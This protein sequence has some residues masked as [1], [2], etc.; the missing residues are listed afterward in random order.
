MKVHAADPPHL[1]RFPLPMTATPFNTGWTYRHPLGPFAAAQGDSATPTPVTLPHDALRD[2][3]RS[4]DV[5]GKGAGAYYPPGAY[6]YLKTFDAPADW[7][8]RAVRLEFQGAFRHAMVFVNDE[9][10]GNRADGYAR[11]FVDIKPYLNLGDANEVR[12]EVRSGQDSRW[13]SGCGLHRPVVL[14]VDEPV[15]IVPDGVRVTTLDV[16]PDQAVVEVATR[17]A[18][19]TLLSTTATLTTTIADPSGRPVES[20]ETPVTLAPGETAL[21]RHRLY[22]P[23]PQRWSV[24]TPQLYAAASTLVASSLSGADSRSEVRTTF[25]VRTI[26]LDPRRGLRINGEPV[27]LRGACLH[28]DNGPL[29]AAAVGRAEERRIELLRAAGF[30]AIRATHNPLSVA[31]LEACDRLGMLVMDEAFDMWTRGKSTHDYAL[32]FPQ[33]WAADLESMVAKDYNHACVIM[34]SLG[35]EIVETGTPHGAR[36]ARR[37]AEHLRVLDPTRLVTNGVNAA[38]AVLDE[39]PAMMAEAGV[40]LNE[41]MANVGDSMN[42]LGSG[43]SVT[44]RTAESSSVL[45]VLGLNYAD[46]RYALDQELFPHRVIVGSE[47]FPSRIGT[48]WPMVREH[49]HVIGDFTWTGWDYLGEVGIGATA[50]AE[51][52]GAVAALERE[53]PYLTAWCGDLD[54]TGWRRPVSFYRE[55]VYGLRTEPYIAVRRPEHSERTVALQSPWAWSDSVSSWTWPGHEGRPVV[56]EVYADAD[57]VA[58]V[59]DG[60]EVARSPVGEQHPLMAVLETSYVPGEL[61]AVAFRGGAETGRTSLATATEPLLAVSADRTRLRADDADLA[62]VTVELRDADG[63]LVTGVDRPVTVQV[64]GAG[65]LAG[66]CSANPKTTERFDADTWYTFDGRALAVVRPTAEGR[67]DISVGADGL[68]PRMLTLEVGP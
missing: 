68:E 17:V 12:V 56:V 22:L 36:L 5:P 42:Q 26:Q 25:G 60:S 7:A 49:P 57:E 59:R 4:P 23:Y 32:D 61:V 29:G 66:L 15:H 16:E 11:F 39:A 18:N 50:Y 41:V 9:F 20:D 21:V 38:L 27:L 64:S 52:P 34:Y 28:H 40:G 35:N 44:R 1:P 6:T 63:R 30:N 8:D 33:W 51:D 31:M 65:R 54:I 67:V 58:L 13:Y 46:S 2:A 53:F 62:F 37:M 14:H 43:D 24:D 3:D 55:I 19:H 48:L 10:A 47:T 45:D